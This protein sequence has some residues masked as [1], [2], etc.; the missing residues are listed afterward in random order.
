MRRGIQRAPTISDIFYTKLGV[1]YIVLYIFC[2]SELF[3]DDFLTLA[4]VKCTGIKF[5]IFL[6]MYYL[7]HFK[8]YS[9]TNSPNYFH[10][11]KL[12]PYTH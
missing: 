11:A 3:H 1:C 12:K 5:T 4:V 9:S 6:K 8:V 7:N 2:I 10:L